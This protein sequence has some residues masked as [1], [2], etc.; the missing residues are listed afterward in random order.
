[1]TVPGDRL[2]DW[3]QRHPRWS[4]ALLALVATLTLAWP[5]LGGR[6]LVGPNSDQYIAGYAF[7]DFAAQ[8][9]RR[10][11]GFPLWNPYQFGGMP[12][13]DAMHGDIFYPTFLLRLILPTDIAMTFGFVLHVALAGLLMMGFLQSSGISW[14]ASAVGGVSYLMSGIVASYASPGHDGKLFVSALL[15]AAL[16]AIGRGMRDRRRAAWGTLALVIGL[17]VL[18][19]HPQL[20]QY[21]LLTSAAFA[22]YL[23]L[24]PL[25]VPSDLAANSDETRAW[26]PPLLKALTAVAIGLSIGAI[27]Y[28]PVKA[29][30]ASSPRA[31]GKGYE[32]ATS[33]SMPIEET[34]NLYLPQFSGILDRYWGRNGIHF[35][36]EYVGA[37]VLVLALYAFGGGML[38]RHRKHAWFWLGVAI[39]GLFWAWGGNTPFYQLIYATIPGST[40]FR[41]PSTILYVVSFAIA[42]LAA[43]GTERAMAGG[44]STRYLAAWIGFAA[45]VGLV[46]SMDG[47]TQLGLRLA[48]EQADR[49]ESNAR[50]VTLGAWRSALAVLAIVSVLW[51][52]RVGRLS[53]ASASWLLVGVVALDLW[54]VDR[55]YW[56]FSSRAASL[57]ATDPIIDFLK[58]R[59]E[60]SRVIALPLSDNLA[61]HDPFLVGDALMIHGIRG[62]MG[63]HGNELRRYQDL[64]GKAEGYQSVA[65]PN[66]WALT[67][68]QY[69]YTNANAVP[70]QNATLVAG[71]VRNAAGTMT[72]LFAL[73]GEHPPAWIA[74]LQVRLDDAPAKA[75][76]LNPNFDVQRVAIFAP[77]AVVNARPVDTPV[78]ARVA[79]VVRATRYEPGAI[80]LRIEGA[81]PEGSALVVSENY[82]PG[83]TAT[84]DGAP[85][86]AFRA[87]YSLIGLELPKRATQISLRYQST[88]FQRGRAI[89][90]VVLLAAVAWMTGGAVA[91]RRRLSTAIS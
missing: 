53:L 20:L 51:A 6:F 1:M 62:V 49:I 90:L 54:S 30:V 23:A 48:I 35:H 87:D 3:I 24:R 4:A 26:W 68:A 91:D 74:P 34:I 59:P 31:G 15:P 38:N 66:F 19:P 42:V 22:L 86:R 85:T 45:V 55:H 72:Y 27:Q 7:R 37:S 25:A 80:D 12:Y 77:D 13:V 28:L 17:A 21:L 56:T 71:P 89:T 75:T 50:D 29:Y 70:F 32:Y 52:S 67:N 82:Y 83:W 65:N 63:Y 73:P 47:F 9:L 39:V 33:F 64:S 58:A 11:E 10:G 81:Y 41:A 14:R 79:A 60:P 78:P 36:S 43:I 5:S 61:P 76:L 46:A 57:Y 8:S 18:S 16:W 88:P 69:F 40:F 2:S 84:I 44:V